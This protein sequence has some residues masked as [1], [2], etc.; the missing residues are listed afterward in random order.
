MKVLVVDDIPVWIKM[1]KKAVEKLGH[2]VTTAWRAEE[3]LEKLEE[4]NGGFDAIVSD[5]R[6]PL[7]DGLA[8]LAR[9]KDRWPNI[10][11]IL[12]SNSYEKFGDEV[13][14]FVYKGLVEEMKPRLERAL[15]T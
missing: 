4:A 5:L 6:M 15:T 11:R 2:E 12:I 13:Q 14:A 10:K 1:I 3:A 7:M 9:V 8:L